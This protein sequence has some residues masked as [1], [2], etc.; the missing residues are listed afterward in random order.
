M[1]QEIF[2]Q[3]AREV[4]A[5]GGLQGG[6]P[7]HQLHQECAYWPAQEQPQHRCRSGKGGARGRSG[8]AQQAGMAGSSR[9]SGEQAMAPPP[10]AFP[11]LAVGRHKVSRGGQRS[12]GSH[13]S[14]MN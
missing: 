14:Y 4:Q 3:Q 7:H 11:P 13:N 1:L 8:R 12:R 10:G 5:S 2:E 9:L 6:Q